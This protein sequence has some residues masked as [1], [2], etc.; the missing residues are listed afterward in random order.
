MSYKF[1]LVYVDQLCYVVQCIC[2]VVEL[3]CVQQVY[4]I[5]SV[6]SGIFSF[7]IM[8]GVV[9]IVVQMDGFCDCVLVVLENFD[10]IVNSVGVFFCEK[11]FVDDDVEGGLVLQV[12]Y[13][14][15]V[16]V[17][18]V[19]L[20]DVDDSFFID[21]FEY[22][23][24]NLLCLVFIIFSVGE[25]KQVG[26]NVLI[27]WDGS[28]ELICVIMVVLFLLCQ[29][30]NVMVVL[31]NFDK[32]LG[33][34]GEQFGVDIV[35]YLVCYGV[36]VEVVQEQIMFDIGNVLFLLVVDKG[37]DLLV[38]GG[39]GYIC[40]CEVLLGGVMLIIFKIMILLVL[41]VY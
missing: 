1:I 31:F 18:Q 20:D 12:C 39:Y 7:I 30:D 24:F 27:V 8:E 5:G 10:K 11:C 3:V 28:M 9:Y 36:K 38:M 6:V 23:M 41:M 14:D 15:L 4:L 2:I 34:Y 13:V 16:V 26:K 21:L 40:F 35:F 37:F 32:C 29:V 22:V 17:S 19:D 33:I 25:F